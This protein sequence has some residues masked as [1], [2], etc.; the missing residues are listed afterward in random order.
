MSRKETFLIVCLLV[1][2]LIAHPATAQEP[3][4][5]SQDVVLVIDN[6]GSMDNQQWAQ[7]VGKLLSD[8]EG[9]RFDAAKLV[10]SYLAVNASSLQRYRIG[11]VSF[12]K[13]ALLLTPITTVAPGDVAERLRHDVDIESDIRTR[14]VDYSFT[15]PHV[16]LEVA[17]QEMITKKSF[18]Q[19]NP[20]SIILI[21]DG[22]F[23]ENSLD[24]SPQEYIKDVEAVVQQLAQKRGRLY[25][26]LIGQARE[27]ENEWRRLANLT[28]GD[29]FSLTDPDELIETYHD[30]IRT[31]V[32]AEALGIATSGAISVKAGG[33]TLKEFDVLEKD[34]PYINALAFTVFQTQADIDVTFI[35]PNGQ[36][37]VPIP[38]KVEREGERYVVTWRIS[39]P[40]Y[41]KWKAEL[42][43]G[44]KDGQ[45]Q[46]WVDVRHIIPQVQ[47][48]DPKRPLPPKQ[49]VEIQIKLVDDL[50]LVEERP[51]AP[52]Q[53]D[54][55]VTLPSGLQNTY[56]MRKD[57]DRYVVL[58]EDTEQ[59][60]EYGLRFIPKASVEG[61]IQEMTRVTSTLRIASVPSIRAVWPDPRVDSPIQAEEPLR[62]EVSIDGVA[63]QEKLQVFAQVMDQQGLRAR[64]PIELTASGTL[65]NVYSGDL[66][67]DKT[68]QYTATIYLT[69]LSNDGI[70]YGPGQ[71]LQ[72]E[73]S[74]SV[75]VV[76]EIPHLEEV[77]FQPPEKAIPTR[78]DVLIYA[79]VSK[80]DK[81][82][83][84]RV[85]AQVQGIKG[86]WPL[87][88]DGVKPDEMAKDEV[89]TGH[90]PRFGH[91][92]LPGFG[93]EGTYMVTLTLQGKDLTGESFSIS[94][95][96][97]VRVIASPL[98]WVVRGGGALLFLMV[99][100]FAGF[101][102][103][104][105]SLQRLPLGTLR[106]LHPA[107]RRGQQWLLDSFESK[108][109]ILG[110]D[111]GHISLPTVEG[112]PAGLY[113]RFYG[114]KEGR[115]MVTYI[116]G[117][118]RE[119]PVLLS[120]T[121]LAKGEKARLFEGST[122]EVGVYT[123]EYLAPRLEAF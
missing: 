33:F 61:S 78:Q 54:V 80:A 113:A 118:S 82:Q 67:F 21:T 41:G 30:L 98:D 43:G 62:L 37:L 3:Q 75:R 5:R 19:T 114:R 49:P 42:R 11:I 110:L 111:A 81:A 93:G 120:G 36:K 50:G 119:R 95:E 103:R 64:A 56:K 97:P 22:R 7:R 109:V 66:L 4:P 34:Y 73:Q 105:R 47:W 6:S 10:I 20:P 94:R 44:S 32:G 13:N 88:D 122:A 121:A 15:N 115:E 68:G 29:V 48:P 52:I 14:R 123:L 108:E 31:L 53:V 91:K 83:D 71:D 84:L 102:W 59:R 99:I 89:F 117:I 23:D 60:G 45:A 90:L 28:G 55:E 104:E 16:A 86:E 2:G 63:E 40:Q 17:L 100:A 65:P 8:P 92:R 72:I 12:G 77:R 27:D 9:R 112:W 24:K 25:V 1:L 96:F 107:E 85:F 58:F 116:E 38:G 76:T 39:R 79:Q 57:K 70:G 26:M 106:V 69:G 87:R 18:Q 101:Q 46:Y 74:F 35:Q 51:N